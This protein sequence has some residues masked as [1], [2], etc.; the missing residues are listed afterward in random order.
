MNAYQKLLVSSFNFED[1]ELNNEWLS[2]GLTG[3]EPSVVKIAAIFEKEKEGDIKING[4]EKA[5]ENWLRGL[6]SFVEI[7]FSDSE[8]IEWG[9][10]SLI[11][12]RS[13]VEAYDND[14]AE[15]QL[16]LDYWD[17]VAN[18]LY[19]MIRNV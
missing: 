11:L 2:Y 3:S 5:L 13:N 1:I 7:P 12:K 14:L 16:L 4:Y 9:Y 19:E 10:D 8:I 18:T 15:E 6:T 17:K